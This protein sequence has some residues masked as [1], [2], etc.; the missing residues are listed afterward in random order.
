MR[1]E[2]II[3][4]SVFVIHNF[5]SPEEC[6][7][8]IQLSEQLGFDDAPIT[9]SQGFVMRKDVRNN[10]RVIVDDVTLAQSLWERA[11][12]FLP[13]TILYWESC[14]FNERFRY[15]RY[16]VGH[17][18]APHYDGYF[19]RDTGERSRLTFMIYLNEGFQG[20][21]T[22]FYIGSDKFIITPETGKALVFQHKLLHEGAPIEKGRKYVLRTDVMY[23][24]PS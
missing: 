17:K 23:R 12:P 7:Q 24:R 4:D 2:S 6:E 10:D 1:K 21:E 19:E 14:G 22:K 20:G 18:F 9:T 16:D 11:E 5:L 8:Y 15:Y 13:P 3:D